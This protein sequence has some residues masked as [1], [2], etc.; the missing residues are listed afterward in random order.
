MPVFRRLGDILTASLND[1][2]DRCEN[3]SAMLRQAIRELES[4][5][6]STLA[7]AVEVVA[8]EKLLA[9]QLAEEK[10]AAEQWRTIAADAVAE[11]DDARAR[12]CLERSLE[13]DDVSAALEDQLQRV[14]QQAARLRKRA[15]ALSAKLSEAQRRYRVLEARERA[16]LSERGTT[17]LGQFPAYRLDRL[18][19]RLDQA[20]ARL[21]A[22]DEVTH[23][24]QVD[25]F[26]DDRR[27][28]R[29]EAALEQLKEP[30]N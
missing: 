12:D 30:R 26:V 9:R 13:H 29:V 25:D 27:R 1:L 20:E 3:P 28:R 21:D 22:N 10:N 2:I 8:T 14:A 17:T 24:W 7:S 16:A 15:A 18:S 19:A 6:E 23:A 11:H 5:V 4:H